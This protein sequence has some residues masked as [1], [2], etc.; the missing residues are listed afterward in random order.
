MMT[1]SIQAKTTI[2]GMVMYRKRKAGKRHPRDTT[3]K[4]I[5]VLG[6]S[7]NTSQVESVLPIAKKKNAHTYLPVFLGHSRSS[8]KDISGAVG[9]SRPRRMGQKQSKL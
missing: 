7:P 4:P 2:M 6:I 3:K 1:F 5:V 8:A 9:K